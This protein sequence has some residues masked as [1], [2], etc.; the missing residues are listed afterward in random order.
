MGVLACC[1]RCKRNQAMLVALQEQ[2][3][4]THQ[5]GAGTTTHQRG[6]FCSATLPRRTISSEFDQRKRCRRARPASSPLQWL[7]PVHAPHRPRAMLL[8]PSASASAGQTWAPRPVAAAPPP[9]RSSVGASRRGA[10][11]CACPGAPATPH[12]RLVRRSTS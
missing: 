11:A 1:F 5:R 10:V 12:L 7:P 3:T 8:T 4:T 6:A 2:E 9:R